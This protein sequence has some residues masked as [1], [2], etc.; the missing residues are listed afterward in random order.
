MDCCNIAAIHSYS[1]LNLRGLILTSYEQTLV[2]YLEAIYLLQ[3]HLIAGLRWMFFYPLDG[4]D[5]GNLL[6]GGVSAER[7]FA[8]AA[9][10]IRPSCIGISL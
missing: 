10:M 8:E 3:N 7:V 1:L 2:V 5:G 6:H 4:D 9:V